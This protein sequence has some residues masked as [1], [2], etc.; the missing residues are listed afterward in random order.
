MRKRRKL[1][2]RLLL[3]IAIVVAF[4]SLY[5]QPPI[6]PAENGHFLEP[7]VPFRQPFPK[8]DSCPLVFGLGHQ[9]SGT[10]AIVFALGSVAN[11]SVRNDVREF[12]HNR[13]LH[14]SQLLEAV[15]SRRGLIQKEGYGLM[16]AR[17]ISRLCPETRFYFVR[18]GLLQTVRS[19][20]DRL[21][22]EANTSCVLFRKKLARSIPLAWRTLFKS[23][24]N[25]SCLVRVA[26]H[27]LHYYQRFRDFELT[28]SHAVPIID[29]EQFVENRSESVIQLC[30]SLGLTCHGE[31]TGQQIYQTQ[32]TNRN[33]SLSELWPPSLIQ[34]LERLQVQNL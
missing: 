19:V 16:Y 8:N 23:S 32:G 18:R 3:S 29:Y 11:M 28:A 15:H 22:L 24:N 26:E 4:E 10:T 30:H 12:W 27:Y 14:D 17:N 21:I 5:Q 2:T 34:Q 6:V 31:M 33:K 9:K 13:Q 20:A 7:E 25:T 1:W